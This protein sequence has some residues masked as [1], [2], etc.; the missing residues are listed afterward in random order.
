MKR[1]IAI[2]LLIPALC[3]GEASRT[4]TGGTTNRVSPG[5]VHN[6]TTGNFTI[7]AWFKGS[8]NAAND[9]IIVKKRTISAITAGYALYQNATDN[10]SVFVADGVATNGCSSG[11]DLDGQWTHATFTWNGTSDAP[12]LY[13]N[14]V[15]ACITAVVA[16]GSLTNTFNFMI[17]NNGLGNEAANGDIAHASFYNVVLND[18]QRREKMLKPDMPLKP[19]DTNFSHWPVWGQSGTNEKDWSTLNLTG[20]VSGTALSTDGP[21]VMLASGFPI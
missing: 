3:F 18:W 10:L 4:F 8:E 12:V 16:M 9:G 14:A 15:G 1:L 5:N 6:V 13:E 7:S 2:I 19:N 17:G 21:P 20:S 11:R